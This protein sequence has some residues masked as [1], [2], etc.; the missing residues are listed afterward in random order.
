MV[1]RRFTERR[2]RSSVRLCAGLLIALLDVQCRPPERIARLRAGADMDAGWAAA[3][4]DATDAASWSARHDTSRKLSDDE[5]DTDAG[6][7]EP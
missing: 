4:S 3:Q 6:T 1:S 7:D 2:R 5:R